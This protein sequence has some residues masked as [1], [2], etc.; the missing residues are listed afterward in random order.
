M[1]LLFEL[2]SDNKLC[3]QN[4]V[5]GGSFM[6]LKK[7]LCR[8]LEI[9]H[10]YMLRHS[11]LRLLFQIWSKLVQDKCPKGRVVLVTE[12]KA[13]FGAL[14]RNPWGDFPEI[15]SV[16]ASCSPTLIFRVS[17]IQVWGSYNLKTLPRPPK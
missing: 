11:D 13:R 5:S 12:N 9:S 8:N 10:R 6:E 7:A 2:Y 1:R 17:S 15:F 16:S 3:T 14:W 4:T